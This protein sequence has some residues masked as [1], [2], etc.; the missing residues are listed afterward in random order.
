MSDM[1]K[2]NDQSSLPSAALPPLTQP[3]IRKRR[4]TQT[5]EALLKVTN[6]VQVLLACQEDYMKSFRN[7]STSPSQPTTPPP[8]SLS[9]SA[10]PPVDTFE[11]ESIISFLPKNSFLHDVEQSVIESLTVR[12]TM[13][14]LILVETTTKKKS[15]SRVHS[16]PSLPRKRNNK[17]SNQKIEKRKGKKSCNTIENPKI[18]TKNSEL[19]SLPLRR[20]RNH[21]QSKSLP[22]DLNNLVPLLSPFMTQS[23]EDVQRRR[24]SLVLKKELKPINVLYRKKQIYRTKK[25]CTFI[26]V[27]KSLHIIQLKIKQQK[28]ALLIT[29]CWHRRVRKLLWIKITSRA[30]VRGLKQLRLATKEFVRRRS[31][32]ILTK[33]IKSTKK[34]ET[35]T[36]IILRLRWKVIKIQRCWKTYTICTK[37]RINSME[38]KWALIERRNRLDLVHTINVLKRKAEKKKGYRKTGK[39]YKASPSPFDAIALE[40]KGGKTRL[41]DTLNNKLKNSFVEETDERSNASRKVFNIIVPCHWT[42]YN[43]PP[44]TVVIDKGVRRE[45]CKQLLELSRAEF[46]KSAPVRQAKSAGVCANISVEAMKLYLSSSSIGEGNED[47]DDKSHKDKASVLLNPSPTID[48]NDVSTHRLLHF[49]NHSKRSKHNYL[50]TRMKQIIE[51]EYFKSLEMNDKR[52]KKTTLKQAKKLFLREVLRK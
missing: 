13:S 15:C 37:E 8:R 44:P 9:R 25:W 4:Y 27:K 29:K 10:P 47:D 6:E 22:K 1:I 38:I 45:H 28:A 48:P 31:I 51:I 40:T 14:N 41:N 26:C 2:N 23:T 21:A 50:I 7:Q 32:K 49:F 11:R 43:T 52:K 16:L 35:F 30:V 46:L 33:F 19:K 5:S 12:R 42:Q 39:M 24:L 3:S 18:E 34:V 36:T 20:G 17:I